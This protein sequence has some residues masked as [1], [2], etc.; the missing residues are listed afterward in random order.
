MGVPSILQKGNPQDSARGYHAV[1]P[2]D[3]DDLPW[4]STWAVYVGGTGDLE[5]MRADGEI[6]IFPGVPAGTQL[7]IQC[8]RI[9]DANTDA[10]NIVAM[11]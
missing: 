2:S 7:M 11:Y 8:K 9:L 6:I 3:T 10:S 5:V 4:G 1:T